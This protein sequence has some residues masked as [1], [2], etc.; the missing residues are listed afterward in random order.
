M[1]TYTY[2]GLEIN[3]LK[4]LPTG[5][6]GGKSYLMLCVVEAKIVSQLGQFLL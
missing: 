5:L 3:V 1:H 6:N 4:G 2:G